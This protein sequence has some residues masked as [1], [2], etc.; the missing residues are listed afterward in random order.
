MVLKSL[1]KAGALLISHPVLW[2]P[3]LVFGL[4]GAADLAA[5][6]LL[7]EFVAGRLWIIEL[8]TI[9]FFTG[10]MMHVI[11]SGDGSIHTFIQG[12][13]K[14]YFRILLPSLIIA[15]AVILTLVLLMLPL[16]I[17]G[18][19][20]ELISLV[21]IGSV[22]G[23]S[24]FTF[25]YDTAVV[26]EDA[27]VFESIRRSVEVVMHNLFTVILFYITVLALTALIM[28]LFAIIWTVFLYEKLVPITTFNAT[29]IE[30]L[31]PAEVSA[32]LGPEGLALTAAL[33]VIAIF[34]VFPLIYSF[35]STFY[36]KFT[37]L[38]ETVTQG[39]YDKKGRW[40]K[41]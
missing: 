4:F 6:S 7:G 38:K 15:F 39:E 28:L 36:Q 1:R 2:I 27:H 13:L 18:M 24:F 5:Q 31:T 29:Q 3:G 16:S 41:Y 33:Y 32:L 34:V 8:I 17:T 21:A 20:Q 26:F 9:P 40:Y 35:K 22:V 25:F 19:G 12:G 37:Q 23:I 14:Y 11:R 30:S 10:A